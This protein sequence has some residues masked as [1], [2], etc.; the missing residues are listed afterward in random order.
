M[1]IINAFRLYAH[2]A[3]NASIKIQTSWKI[4]GI[5]KLTFQKHF[6]DIFQ[7]VRSNG[8]VHFMDAVKQ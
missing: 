6:I 8:K 5:L 3:C 7:A 2:Y 1:N 4:V